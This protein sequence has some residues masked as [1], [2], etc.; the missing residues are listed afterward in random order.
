MRVFEIKGYVGNPGSRW[1]LVIASP[2][3]FARDFRMPRIRSSVGEF[4][5]LTF[6]LLFLFFEPVFFLL[7]QFYG[8]ISRLAG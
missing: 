4:L 7:L 1:P 5:R 3:I 6:F 8:F 2:A